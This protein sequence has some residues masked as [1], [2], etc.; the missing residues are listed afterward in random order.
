ML[1]SDEVEID[2]VLPFSKSLHDGTGN[3]VLCT[4]QANRDKGDRTPFEAF[5]H[6][7]G[8][9]NWDEIME[10]AARLPGRKPRLF[11]PNALESFLDGRDFLDRQLIDTGYL[12]RAASATSLR[13]ARPTGS[14]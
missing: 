12:A 1:F 4:R 6:S 3:K 9:Y 14:G 8:I 10:R 7:P 13:C 2:H 11:Q 5:G